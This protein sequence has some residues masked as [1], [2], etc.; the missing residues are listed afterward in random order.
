MKAGK[1]KAASIIATVDRPFITSHSSTSGVSNAKASA[2]H[3][4]V[5]KKRPRVGIKE[6][7]TNLHRGEGSVE[8][9]QM[10][11]PYH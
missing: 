5:L 6:P 2:D 3:R 8:G 1:I 10:S 4:P 9:H 11:D 7:A